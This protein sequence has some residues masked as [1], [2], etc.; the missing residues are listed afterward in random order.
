MYAIV[1]APAF[2][3]AT[4]T[5]ICTEEFYPVIRVHDE[6]RVGHA[7][8]RGFHIS[9]YNGLVATIINCVLLLLVQ[10]LSANAIELNCVELEHFQVYTDCRVIVVVIVESRDSG[11]IAVT[12]AIVVVVNAILF[13]ITANRRGRI[14]FGIP[15]VTI[16]IRN[17]VDSLYLKL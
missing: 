16:D 6:V 11:S 10:L 17:K 15:L 12:L 13:I 1:I 14:N 3:V 7:D 5:V 4:I 8:P 9:D 2:K